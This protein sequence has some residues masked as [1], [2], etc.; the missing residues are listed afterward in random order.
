MSVNE[1]A[2]APMSDP[3]STRAQTA[4]R[5]KLR[6]LRVRIRRKMRPVLEVLAFF[7]AALSALLELF[8]GRLPS[9]STKESVCPRDPETA[10][11]ADSSY[12]R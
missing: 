2:F 12:K 7:C 8:S 1:Y 11:D 6:R 3:A 4:S 10:E 9:F 5:S